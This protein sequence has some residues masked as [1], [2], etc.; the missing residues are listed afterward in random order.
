V[1][2]AKDLNDLHREGKQVHDPQKTARPANEKAKLVPIRREL[3]AVSLRDGFERIVEGAQA[4]KPAMGLKLGHFRLDSRMCGLRRGYVAALGGRTSYGKTSKALQICDLNMAEHSVLFISVEDGEAMSLKRL[5]AR[6]ANVN[7]LRLRD[8]KCSNKELADM[9]RELAKAERLPFF[10]DAVGVPVEDICVLIRQHCKEHNTAL[11]VFDYLQKAKSKKRHHERRIEVGENAQLLG[12]TIKE[13]GAAG[14]LLSQ[15][16]R[17]DKNK[18]NDPPGMHDLKE[19]GELENAVEHVL[20]GHVAESMI[21]DSKAGTKL[22]TRSVKI[23][24]NKDGPV[25]DEWIDENFDEYTASFRDTY[26]GGQSER[27]EEQEDLPL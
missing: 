15:L 1:S 11:V 18:P 22:R 7:A 8:N 23:F 6:R 10:V 27:Y 24:K 5:M 13:A 12:D 19:A 14:L 9:R 26:P 17:P 2:D 20:I 25:F 21:P 3:R 16:S 4:G